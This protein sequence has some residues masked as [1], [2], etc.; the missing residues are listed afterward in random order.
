[1]ENTFYIGLIVEILLCVP[2]IKVIEW[3]LDYAIIAAAYMTA[4]S[5]YLQYFSM[6]NVVISRFLLI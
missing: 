3:R 4:C 5:Y 2:A 6:N 1:M